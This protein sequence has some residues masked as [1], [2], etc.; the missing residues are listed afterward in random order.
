[1]FNK[2]SNKVRCYVCGRVVGKRVKTGEY[3][4]SLAVTTVKK[5]DNCIEVEKKHSK[6]YLCKE[7]YNKGGKLWQE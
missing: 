4:N 2:N 7:C 1:M 3:I 5:K 6:Y